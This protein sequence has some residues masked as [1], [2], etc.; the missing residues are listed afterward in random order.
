MGQMCGLGHGAAMPEEVRGATV[1][2]G[3]GND[4]HISTALGCEETEGV[5]G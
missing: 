5:I 2:G 4:L 1:A 3:T